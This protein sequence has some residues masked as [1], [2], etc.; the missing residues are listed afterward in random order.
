MN[1]DYSLE[2]DRYLPLYAIYGGNIEIIRLLMNK[3]IQILDKKEAF[4][5][6][7][8]TS[9]SA[10]FHHSDLMKWLIQSMEFSKKQLVP[11]ILKETFFECVKSNFIDGLLFCI[12]QN[13]DINSVDQ[14]NQ[15]LLMVSIQNKS[16]AA[17]RLLIEWGV[18]VRIKSNNGWE[19]IHYA[20][21]SNEQKAL[22]MLLNAYKDKLDLNVQT[23]DG[24]TP[25]HLSLINSN[26]LNYQILIQNGSNENI[27]NKANKSPKDIY[28][29]F[30]SK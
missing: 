23:S 8:H 13:C 2:K 16:Y 19:A 1:S 17:L 10:S 9:Q 5:Y 4:N 6:T 25:L 15:S 3:G 28:E 7:F 18:N 14:Y 29:Q 21:V 12:E 26:I 20:A 24:N 30:A 27:Q 22:E 11:I